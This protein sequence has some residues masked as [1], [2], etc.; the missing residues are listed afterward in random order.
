MHL[1]PRHS[2]SLR[3]VFFSK[4]KDDSLIRRERQDAPL[5]AAYVTEAPSEPRELEFKSPKIGKKA[6]VFNGFERNKEM[7]VDAP[8]FT[9]AVPGY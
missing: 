6:R 3:N 8:V 9:P 5:D 7:T 2:F 1:P 4:L